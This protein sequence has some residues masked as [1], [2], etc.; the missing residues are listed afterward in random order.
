MSSSQQYANV[1]VKSIF[2]YPESIAGVP[3]DSARQFRPT[4]LLHTTCVRSCCTWRASCVAA[5]NKNKNEILLHPTRKTYYRMNEISRKFPEPKTGICKKYEERDGRRGCK[6]DTA[7]VRWVMAAETQG[8]YRSQ[9]VCSSIFHTMYTV[10]EWLGRK[11]CWVVWVW[12]FCDVLR[13]E[14]QK[15]HPSIRKI[16]HSRKSSS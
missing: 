7:Q 2:L 13:P 11:L 8:Q 4:L 12:R 14:C 15:F 16:L 3:F 9:A 10:T 1:Y 6:S 5:F